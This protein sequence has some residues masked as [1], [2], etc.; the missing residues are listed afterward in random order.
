M[1][2]TVCIISLSIIRQDGRVLRQ[3]DYLSK[4]YKVHVIGYGSAPQRYYE[5]PKVTWH[6]LPYGHSGFPLWIP[7]LFTRLIQAPF[8]PRSHP[9]FRIAKQLRCDA[10]HANNWD[11]LAFAAE[12]AKINASKLVLDIHESYDA[13]YWG[14]ITPITKYILKKYSKQIDSSTTAGKR[15]AEQHKQF[16]LD[17]VVVLNTP[18]NSGFNIPFRKTEQDRIRLIHHGPAT[19]ART[20]DLMIKAIALSDPCYELHLILTNPETKYVRYLKDLVNQTVPG[21]V[22]FHPPVDP[23]DIVSEISQYEIGFFPLPPK[24]Y[25]YLITLPNKLFEFMAAGLAVCIGPSLSMAEIVREY[26]CGVVSPS[27]DPADIAR[28]LNDTSA[29]QWNEMRKASLQAA[30]VL[31]AEKEMGKVLEIYRKLFKEP[32]KEKNDELGTINA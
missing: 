3:I 5:S 23:F 13:W 21:R 18:K 26:H 15:Y 30:Q 28:V 19:Q 25:N 22:T 29:E 20:S 10:Y 27:F 9:V 8:F 12:A 11:A 6:E 1:K 31:N 7:R 24:N 2:K 4:E 16:G 32:D 14:W 17:P